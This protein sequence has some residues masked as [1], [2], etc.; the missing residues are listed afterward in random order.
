M[1]GEFYKKDKYILIFAFSFILAPAFQNVGINI[2]VLICSLSALLVAVQ[3]FVKKELSIFQAPFSHIDWIMFILAGIGLIDGILSVVGIRSSAMYGFGLL[4]IPLMYFA[5]RTEWELVLECMNTIFIGGIVLIVLSLL[6]FVMNT[7]IILGIGM[8]DIGLIEEVAVFIGLIGVYIYSIETKKVMETIYC[9][10]TVGC[11]ICLA[12]CG[13]DVALIL[14]ILGI[15]LLIVNADR[16]AV[17]VKKLLMCLFLSLFIS[18]N[19]VLLVNYTSLIKVEVSVWSLQASVVAELILALV[20]I[21]VVNYWD[22][23]EENQDGAIKNMQN[24]FKTLFRY[25]AGIG[26]SFVVLGLA[27]ITMG[28]ENILRLFHDGGWNPDGIMTSAL[29]EFS[30]R[31]GKNI[32]AA[33]NENMFR[34]VFEAYGIIGV[35]LSVPI[36]G[37]ISYKVWKAGKRTV[38]K[39]ILI[40]ILSAV[41]VVECVIM[42]VRPIM[43][44]IYALILFKL[45]HGSVKRE[46]ENNVVDLVTEEI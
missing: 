8:E 38:K 43:L 18:C 42:P 5:A 20:A 25:L 30:A 40:W 34:V 13:N 26:L 44:P 7:D 12:L 17:V 16:E 32:T 1:K 2:P 28:V 36:L 29:L 45:I 35:L 33:Y 4:S 24:F 46:V 19:A 3:L 14:F 21:P 27:D 15:C 22:K 11:M 23:I 31:M 37:L 41:I 9:I 6:Y 10:G 39:D